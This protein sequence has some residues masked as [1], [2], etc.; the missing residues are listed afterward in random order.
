MGGGEGSGEVCIETR[1]V[2]WKLYESADPR[3]NKPLQGLQGLE[4]IIN[5]LGFADAGVPI[6]NKLT[7]SPTAVA[8]KSPFGWSPTLL[9]LIGNASHAFPSLKL[10]RDN[11]LRS[12]VKREM[13]GDLLL[14]IAPDGST[15]C[16]ASS[17]S[18]QVIIEQA[19]RAE[20]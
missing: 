9:E 14:K 13:L 15:A 5:V 12:F 11:P 16:S 6:A 1:R 18:A 10:I 17:N 8:H 20:V 2:T 7:G 4:E 19:E 3:E